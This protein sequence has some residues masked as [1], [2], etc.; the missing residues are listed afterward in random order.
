MASV[1]LKQTRKSCRRRE[2]NVEW[3]STKKL[4][5]KYLILLYSLAEVF[6]GETYRRRLI[7]INYITG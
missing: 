7:F 3:L 1:S 5:V 4:P 2:R 6:A